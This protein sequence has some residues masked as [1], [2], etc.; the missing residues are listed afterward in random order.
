M[1]QITKLIKQYF[2]DKSLSQVFKMVQDYY[3]TDISAW[4]DEKLV[5]A[6]SQMVEAM[7]T[8]KETNIMFDPMKA[9][10][11]QLIFIDNETIE[12][13]VSQIEK[14]L[15]EKEHQTKMY[16]NDGYKEAFETFAVLHYADSIVIKFKDNKTYPIKKGS[17]KRGE[18][19]LAEALKK[20]IMGIRC[21]YPDRKVSYTLRPKWEGDNKNSLQTLRN[22]Y[23]GLVLY[24]GEYARA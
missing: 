13:P 17:L 1:E 20:G 9:K 10:W 7:T 16:G 21:I 22:E 4:S 24:L 8:T 6:L 2:P 12:V 18:V 14:L 3:K 23:G 19:N 11:I 15:V 5:K